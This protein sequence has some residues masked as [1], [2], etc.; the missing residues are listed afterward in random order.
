MIYSKPKV[1][2]KPPLKY[3]TMYLLKDCKQTGFVSGFFT[4]FITLHINLPFHTP[5]ECLIAEEAMQS[6][7][8]TTK[9]SSVTTNHIYNR[10]CQCQYHILFFP[11]HT[12]LR[13]AI[14]SSWFLLLQ[15]ESRGHLNGAL[16]FN[17][18][19]KGSLD[20]SKVIY[21]PFDQW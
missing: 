1:F 7:N 3:P 11:L 2:M 13:A 14:A 21:T 4:A 15:I 8:L 6:A 18:L 5:S 17:K 10:G 9:L 12:V 19:A 20:M 16:H